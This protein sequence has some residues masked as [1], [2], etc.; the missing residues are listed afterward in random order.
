MA[1]IAT[2]SPGRM[3]AREKALLR[4]SIE[5]IRQYLRFHLK[6]RGSWQSPHVLERYAEK[7]RTDLRGIDSQGR[8][9]ETRHGASR[10]SDRGQGF[11]WVLEGNCYR[12]GGDLWS[13]VCPGMRNAKGC[14]VSIRWRTRDRMAI[15]FI[16]MRHRC[17]CSHRPSMSLRRTRYHTACVCWCRWTGIPSPLCYRRTTAHRELLAC[18][19]AGIPR[20]HPETCLTST[21]E[22]STFRER[23][24]I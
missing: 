4:R 2:A 21:W 6:K 3:G 12:G 22:V 15:R 8:G 10:A 7:G 9:R 23:V 17:P 14:L 16:R 20:S 18:D 11:R 24:G 5:D 1:A 13:N 19:Q